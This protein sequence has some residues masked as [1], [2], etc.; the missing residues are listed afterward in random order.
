[1][2]RLAT[3]RN[4]VGVWPTGEARGIEG[5]TGFRTPDRGSRSLR[6]GTG[7]T[8]E[9]SLEIPTSIEGG[10][11]HLLIVTDF[12][13]DVFEVVDQH[14][15]RPTGQPGSPPARYRDGGFFALLRRAG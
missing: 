9:A 15:V 5:R 11:Y 6:P 7:D 2:T 8:I 13:D 3:D 12:F 4:M 14:S 1:M 10:L